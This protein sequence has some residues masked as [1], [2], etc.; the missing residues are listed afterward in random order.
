MRTLVPGRIAGVVAAAFLLPAVC[1]A[2][3]AAHTL[4]VAPSTGLALSGQGVQVSG[5]FSTGGPVYIVEAAHRGAQS[6]CNTKAY[7]AP[8]TPESYAVTIYVRGTLFHESALVG[9]ADD[10]CP[11]PAMP[12]NPLCETGGTNSCAVELR[13]PVTGEVLASAPIAFAFPPPTCSDAATGTSVDRSVVIDLAAGCSDPSGRGVSVELLDGPHHGALGPPGAS[14][15]RRYTP[16]TDYV[17]PD[18]LTVRATAGDQR[19]NVA[20]VHINV[21]G[22]DFSGARRP[23]FFAYHCGRF[24]RR[25]YHF[26][27]SPT[28]GG[29]PGAPPDL[30]TARYPMPFNP[31]TSADPGRP[32][33]SIVARDTWV[34]YA[35]TAAF[36]VPGDGRGCRGPVGPLILRPRIAAPI[37]V[38][39]AADVACRFKSKF[40]YLALYGRTGGGVP[41][42]VRRAVAF[43]IIT[44]HG[45]VEGYRTVLIAKLA[46][47]RSLRYDPRRCAR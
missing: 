18:E 40:S 7:L 29:D 37:R 27:F 41:P 34:A 9:R 13:R 14:G 36:A 5:S 30:A 31:L 32:H 3:A 22:P 20:T 4:A 21:S 2:P 15:R 19:S 24:G 43:E 42:A 39:H 44:R 12:G 16:A 10:P 17:G 38:T 23:F 28:G 33:V 8:T 35:D 47:G 1:V 26:G 6:Y 45:Q 11:D 25:S 46:G